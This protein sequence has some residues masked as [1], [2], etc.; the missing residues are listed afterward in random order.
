MVYDDVHNP[1]TNTIPH[2]S[3][4]TGEVYA[5]STKA[6]SQDTHNKPP[7]VYD[8]ARV[9]MQRVSKVLTNELRIYI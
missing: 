4:D 7:L 5:M 6:V 9:D 8:Y 2:K 3:T 1:G